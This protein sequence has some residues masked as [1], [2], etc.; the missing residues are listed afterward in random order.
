MT[1]ENIKTIPLSFVNAFLV[2]ADGGF[3]LID[4]G[5]PGQWEKLEKE[6][7]S[8]SCLPGNLKLVILTHGDMDHSGNCKKLQ[9]KYN[10]RIAMHQNDYAIIETGSPGKRKV[11]FLSR[12]I[13]FALIIFLRKLKKNKINLNKFNPDIFLQDG[14]SL[15]EYGFNARVIHLPGHTKGSIGILTD[16]GDLF[17]G[18]TLVNRKKPETAAIIENQTD[19]EK[20][21][22]K[23]R[24]LNI[25]MVYPGHGKPFPMNS[26]K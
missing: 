7:I 6:L 26:L 1:D 25:R 19:L 10:A 5:L 22:E 20:S 15:Q 2:K 24:K 14:Q 8:D 18:D 9:E 21:I 12:K 23:L 17:A 16:Q 4:T 11:K 3:V 13:I